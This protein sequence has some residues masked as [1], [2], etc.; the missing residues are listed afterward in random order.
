MKNRHLVLIVEDDA[1]ISEDLREILSSID[2]D[3]IIVSNKED[4]LTE[5]EQNSICLVLL[6]LQIK[7]AS[8]AIKA[9]VEHGKSLLR[10]IRE[11][12]TEHNGT[13]FCLPIL[14]ISGFA[15]EVDDAV[16][17]MKDNASDIVQKPFN[18]QIVSE[19]I[20]RALFVSGRQTHDECKGQPA[21]RRADFKGGVVIS[22]PGDRAKRRTAIRLGSH[23]VM[24]TDGALKMLLHLVVA[25]LKATQVNK[26]DLGA[27][28]DQG[29]KGMSI[30]RDAL[31]PI[32]GDLDIIKNHYHGNYS[33]VPNVSIGKCAVDKLMEIG[34]ST[35]SDLAKKIRDSSSRLKKQSEG[36]SQNFPTQR[37]RR[38]K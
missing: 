2:C 17:L 30:L 22:I 1:E 28:S 14:V 16:E 26:V 31:K 35:I 5:L 27:T 9:H 3:S 7:G 25:Q 23:T 33:F 18:S 4:A 32:L 15:R 6:D 19:R 10:K 8:D 21:V 11:K 13:S 38:S 24:L 36:N 12:H 37:R 20:R 29:F 34:D